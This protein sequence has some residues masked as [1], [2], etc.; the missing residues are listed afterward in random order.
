MAKVKY[1]YD[2]DTLSYRKIELRK[3]DKF[4]Q[5]IVFLVASALDGGFTRIYDVSVCRITKSESD[6]K[7]AGEHETAL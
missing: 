6:E 7:R 2:S 3:R 1:Y 4:R 5:T